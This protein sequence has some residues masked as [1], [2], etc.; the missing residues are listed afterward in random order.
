M[1]WKNPK[2]PKCRCKTKKIRETVEKWIYRC[3]N[4]G[5]IFRD[6]GQVKK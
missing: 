1:P 3:K 5:H 2:C 6:W 4:C